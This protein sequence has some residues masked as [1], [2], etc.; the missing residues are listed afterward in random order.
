MPV[1]QDH[2]V[3]GEAK[4]DMSQYN[5]DDYDEQSKSIGDPYTRICCIWLIYTSV[6]AIQ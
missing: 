1:D 6:W 2:P 3:N 5:L 4:D